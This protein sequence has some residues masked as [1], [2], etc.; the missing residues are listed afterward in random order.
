MSLQKKK[1]YATPKKKKSVVTVVSSSPP[2][3]VVGSAYS[4]FFDQGGRVF[5]H[6]GLDEKFATSNW[7]DQPIDVECQDKRTIERERRERGGKKFVFFFFSSFS[8]FKY[9]TYF[10]FDVRFFLVH[11]EKCMSKITKRTSLNKKLTCKNS[12]VLKASCRKKIE[13]PFE[14]TARIKKQAPERRLYNDTQAKKLTYR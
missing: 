4:F 8:F 5:M 6:F 11:R 14:M 2:L 10:Y 7:T 12:L 9:T 3:E 1:G 13:F